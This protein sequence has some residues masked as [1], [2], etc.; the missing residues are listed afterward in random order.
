MRAGRLSAA[1]DGEPEDLETPLRFEIEPG[2]PLLCVEAVSWDERLQPFESYRA[3]HR[4]D[5][6]K[7]EVQVVHGEVAAKAGLGLGGLG[8]S[9]R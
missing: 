1:I 5:R 4:A 2:A 7:I 9:R 6:T 8:L 3:W